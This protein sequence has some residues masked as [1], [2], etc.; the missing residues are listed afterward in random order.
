MA[1]QINSIHKIKKKC[2][3]CQK[4]S[5]PR[6]KTL[7]KVHIIC[8]EM[9]YN[10][11]RLNRKFV[12]GSFTVEHFAVKHI[13]PR[14][15]CRFFRRGFF[16][17]VR[18]FPRTKFCCTIFFKVFLFSFFCWTNKYEAFNTTTATIWYR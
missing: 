11:L 17:A 5:Y 10:E 3:S 18:T 8:S 9:F 14:N 15:F 12:V 6:I 13:A 16:F 2:S 4:N 1:V 7:Q